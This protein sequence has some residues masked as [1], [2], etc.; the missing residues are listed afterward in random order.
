[1]RVRLGGLRLA[2]P[3]AEQSS[4]GPMDGAEHRTE[5]ESPGSTLAAGL[6][7]AVLAM[8][9]GFGLLISLLSGFASDNCVPGNARFICTA[10]GQQ[11]TLLIGVIGT[12]VVGVAALVV[13]W[14]R[15]AGQARTGALALGL[16][17]T[18]VWVASYIAW[19]SSLSA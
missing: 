16:F 9:M 2:E 15:P 19:T 7:T 6:L 5:H 14:R 11:A 12:L 17:I 18:I 4:G 8:V 1:M 10:G 3:V 13:G